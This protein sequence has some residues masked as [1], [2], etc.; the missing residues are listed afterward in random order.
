MTESASRLT[1][2]AA[3]GSAAR[4]RRGLHFGFSPSRVREALI[5]YLFLTPFFIFFGIFVLRSI[6]FSGYMSLF[7][8][9]V[10]AP[11]Q[12]Y[13]GFQNYTELLNDDIWWL[14]LRNTFIFAVLTVIGTTLLALGVALV[15]NRRLPGSGVFRSIFYA[16]SI[17]SVGV[18][19]ICWG[20]LLSSE[21]GV[22]N[23]FL[24]SLGLNPV[25][26][27]GNPNNALSTLSLVTIWW[28]FGFPM[29]ILLAGLQNIPEHYREAAR[30]D[31]A[32]PSQ[33]FLYITLP[34][35]RPTLLFVTV[36][37]FIAHFQVFGQPYIMTNSGGPGRASYTVIIYIYEA[38]WE[39]F[40]MGYA[41]AASFTLA[42][43]IMVITLI[44]FFFIGRRTEY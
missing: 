22:I 37:G 11:T 9:R 41:A 16:P 42:I 27:L 39:A 12:Q 30:I 6:V 32:G 13:I 34:L 5:A 15:L 31:G 25:N 18:V 26:W 1:A 2:S 44:Q 17:L 23:Y 20:W 36:T 29:L 10:M 38:A 8:W 28:G 21:F 3:A 14:A 40:R 19:A 43:I 24:R 4:S 7:N 35:L 33:V